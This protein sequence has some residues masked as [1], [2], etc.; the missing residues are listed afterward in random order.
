MNENDFSIGYSFIAH[1]GF[2]FM[3]TEK[4]V[5][6]FL[7]EIYKDNPKNITHA[8]AFSPINAQFSTKL[9][10]TKEFGDFTTVMTTLRAST[11]RIFDV[12]TV[13]ILSPSQIKGVQ[14]GSTNIIDLHKLINET[15]SNT[16][17]YFN[18]K[19]VG[20]D[21]QYPIITYFSPSEYY[22]IID[23]NGQLN[24]IESSNWIQANDTV[25][26]KFTFNTY[27]LPT[28]LRG[29]P[30]KG[31]DMFITS[32]FSSIIGPYAIF[33]AAQFHR[34]FRDIEGNSGFSSEN[35]I[36]D[37]L[38]FIIGLMR[39][40]SWLNH[41]L[42]ELD[43]LDDLTY[44][45]LGTNINHKKYRSLYKKYNNYENG[46]VKWIEL[47]NRLYDEIE[48]LKMTS[49]PINYETKNYEVG[50]FDYPLNLPFGLKMV[51]KPNSIILL[52]LE[53]IENYYNELIKKVSVIDKKIDNLSNFFNS[54]LTISSI[55]HT[56]F[57][58]IVMTI[59]T[60]IIL[61]ATIAMLKN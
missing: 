42:I 21:E 30:Y 33:S 12:L 1:I 28:L 29:E 32:R 56:R 47:S 17:L 11:S 53:N 44:S 41:R 8:N 26:N 4:N 31:S 25:L 14:D 2:A 48:G 19:N 5:E 40:F 52:Q 27:Q 35:E 9:Y 58:T 38:K 43:N 10:E 13:A 45:V 3:G 50:I 22:S 18:N 51:G 46:R 39:N 20:L 6:E 60:L 59:M 7:T 36:Y 54:S 23:Q 61:G 34:F 24:L 55:R 15:F 37:D 16:D 57:H 49:T